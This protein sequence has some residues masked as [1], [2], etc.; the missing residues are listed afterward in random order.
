MLFVRAWAFS[1][2]VICGPLLLFYFV[3]KKQLQKSGVPFWSLLFWLGMAFIGA[4]A[5]GHLVGHQIKQ[6]ILPISLVAG[7]GIDSFVRML[8][9]AAPRMLAWLYMSLVVVL[10]PYESIIIGIGDR[11]LPNG[12][13]RPGKT[14]QCVS[15]RI[16]KHIQSQTDPADY[17]YFWRPASGQELWYS[18]RRCPSRYF[19]AIFRFMPDFESRIAADCAAHPPKLIVVNKESEVPVPPC[20]R[21]LL[22]KDYSPSCEI[23]NYQVFRR[24]AQAGEVKAER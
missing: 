19:N 13:P 14:A 18:Q 20:I 8:G 21:T 6:V 15:D 3:Q 23:G 7:L 2:L 9:P 4:N 17:V 12:V 22:A 10:L 5:S 24:N 1:P 11:L 16:V